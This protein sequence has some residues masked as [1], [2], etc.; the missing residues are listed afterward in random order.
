MTDQTRALNDQVISEF[1]DNAGVVA[2]AMNGHFANIHL[3][4]LHHRGRRSGREYVT[5]LLYVDDHD[6]YVLI[7]S[8]GGAEKEPAWVANVAAQPEV[9]IEIG[10]QTITAKPTVV[11]EGPEWDRLHAATVDYWPDVLEYLTHTTR[12]FPMIVLDP[13][14]Q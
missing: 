13:V 6:R 9:Q 12:A 14:S 3:L 7:G 1:R 4:L 2:N 10:G 8:N 5:P 11:R